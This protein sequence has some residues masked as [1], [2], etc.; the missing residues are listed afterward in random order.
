MSMNLICGK[1]HGAL[2]V[3]FGSLPVSGVPTT[4]NREGSANPSLLE[5]KV[6]AG[7]RKGW[8]TFLVSCRIGFLVCDIPLLAAVPAVSVFC[9]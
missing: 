3:C 9:P 7:F 4:A 8:R 2:A 5:R 6:T 1:Q